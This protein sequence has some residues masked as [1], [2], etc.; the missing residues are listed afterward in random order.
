MKVAPRFRIAAGLV[1]LTSAFACVPKAS[2]RQTDVM[3][4]SGAVTISAFELRARVNELA[5]RLAG[6]IAETAG[7]IE[8]EAGDPAL[9]RRAVAFK[10]DA[11]PALYT[12]AF[13]T[14]PLTALV[15]VWVFSF[16]IE[17]FLGEGA[18]R[19]AFGPQQE[20][21]QEGA[22]ALVAAADAAV[23]EVVA[24]PAAYAQHRARF[25]SWAR[26][27]PLDHFATRDS[28]ASLMAG[29]HPDERDTFAAVGAATETIENVSER[30]NTYINLLPRQ[31]HWQFEILAADLAAEHD[32]E[33][34]LAEMHSVG[35]SARSFDALVNQVPELLGGTS[36]PELV[37]AERREVLEGIAAE[38]IAAI[39]FMTSERLEVLRAVHE[40]RIAA[41]ET[42]RQERIA[43]LQEA[44]AL[45]KRAWDDASA[46]L[47]RLVDYTLVRVAVLLSFLMI[48]GA[49]L[50][51]LG[52]RLT[53]GRQPR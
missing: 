23:Q 34:F 47:R 20:V 17:Q 51:V 25:E 18:G 43:T 11:I 10:A 35:V 21:A 38:R 45:R 53:L 8:A 22:R 41:L 42:L 32:V 3:E 27:H 12:A 4:R 16:Q 39:Q 13:R 36:I 50:G 31:I 14:D 48:A 29:L 5:D 9:R 46:D 40:E 49:L 1:A 19:E 6:R 24:T 37:A 44:E 7:R 28:V 2:L 52:Y 30:L 15:D 26:E 33:G